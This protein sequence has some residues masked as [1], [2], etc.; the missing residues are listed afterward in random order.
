MPPNLSK[1]VLYTSFR[2]QYRF[3]FKPLQYNQFKMSESKQYK[4]LFVMCSELRS[5]IKNLCDKLKILRE[6]KS[7]CQHEC[8]LNTVQEEN[9]DDLCENH[10][11]EIFD[12]ISTDMNNII[13][14]VDQANDY[15][16]RE[17]SRLD[18]DLSEVKKH[19]KELES[20]KPQLN[21][22]SEES[23]ADHKCPASQNAAEVASHITVLLSQTDYLKS[24]RDLHKQMIKNL[25]LEV[26]QIRSVRARP[27]YQ[28][29]HH[30][31]RGHRPR[32]CYNCR[33]PGHEARNCRRPNPRMPRQ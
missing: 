14:S 9:E 23:K 2:H 10:N 7:S 26:S 24:S 13:E 6:S 5:E 12:N 11:Q 21:A 15:T 22:L 17:A 3:Y 18:K 4:S 20:S 27:Q 32:I 30:Q 16:E 25:E 28:F 8:N 1:N 31:F 29:N 33:R 19:V